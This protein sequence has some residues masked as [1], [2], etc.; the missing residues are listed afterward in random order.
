MDFMQEPRELTP[1]QQ[2]YQ[3]ALD[4]SKQRLD[5]SMKVA[6]PVNPDVRARAE[7]LST[8][9]GIPISVVEND[10][11]GIEL[12]DRQKKYQRAL[13][14]NASPAM[15]EW[16]SKPENAMVSHDDMNNM[17]TFEWLV[18]APVKAWQQGSATVELGRLGSKA[19]KQGLT[20][21]EE[22]RVT[23][24][25]KQSGESIGADG[26]AGKVY[27]GFFKSL[28]MIGASIGGGI[29]RGTEVGAGFATV[30]ALAGQAGPQIATPEELITVPSAYLMGLGVGGAYGAFEQSAIL[31]GGHA[32][33]E[34]RDIRGENGEK[35]DDGVA[36]IAARVV[37]AVNGSIELLGLGVLAKSIPGGKD[38]LN[39]FSKNEI[40]KQLAKPTV[41]AALGN[42]S[43]RFAGVWS[44]EV[45]QE[46][47]QEAVTIIG[48]EISK[49]L[50]EGEFRNVTAGEAGERLK[51]TA[52]QAAQE[53]AIISA[54]GPT[55]NFAVDVVRANRAKQIQN[56]FQSMSDSARASKLRERLPERFK[57]FVENATKDGGIEE[58]YIP[59]DKFVEYFQGKHIDPSE[60]AKA[61]PAIN[62]QLN[63]ALRSGSDLIIPIGDF[64]A[65]IAPSQHFEGLQEHL[66]LRPDEMTLNEALAFDGAK[67]AAIAD[68]SQ[69]DEKQKMEASDGQV[70]QA[71]YDKL[72][73]AG[74]SQDVAKMEAT[75]MAAFFTTMADRIGQDPME[76]FA[77]VGL[78]IK[79]PIPE[80]IKGKN[81]DEVDFLIDS[82]R[83]D[84]LPSQGK[85]LLE[86]VRERGIRDDR[87]DLAAMDID[88]TKTRDVN[89]RRKLAA[90]ILRPDG[91]T[92]D[93]VALAAQELGYF[94]DIPAGERVTVNQ[95]LDAMTGAEGIFANVPGKTQDQLQAA[96]DLIQ[97]LDERGIVLDETSN[98]DIKA[99]L[100]EA[101]LNPVL[102]EDGKT[103]FHP[104]WHGSPHKFSK[105]SL[106]HMGTGEGNQAY[107]WGL[108][109]AGKKEVAEWYRDAGIMVSPRLRM[110]LDNHPDYESARASLQSAIRE[111]VNGGA[112]VWQPVLDELNAIQ[113]GN[114]YQ[115]NLQPTEDQYLDWD[116]PL[117][118][119][120]D[121]VK[122]ML[123]SEQET[124]RNTE[125][126]EGAYINN[127]DGQ[128][129]YKEFEF[130]YGTP[131]EALL[132]LLELGIPGV[133]YLDMG[134]RN[135]GEGTNNYV[136][137][138]D[139]L[140]E[141]KEMYQTANEPDEFTVMSAD[142]PQRLANFKKWFGDSKVVDENGD[143]LVVY[144]GT[145]NVENID[146]FK[147]ELT[148]RG[149]DQLGSGFYFTNN[150]TTASG[151]SASR[152]M[153]D[154]EKLGGEGAAG[155]VP[156][157]L[158][159]QNP[160]ELTGTQ[161]NLDKAELNLSL[162]DVIKIMKQSP[163]IY[164][165]EMTPI[166]NWID[167]GK[168]PVEDW[169]IEDVAKNYTGDSLLSLENDMF[170]DEATAFRKALNNTLGYDGVIQKFDNGE[171]HYVAWFPEQIKSVFNRGTFD[172][173]DARI[174]YQEAQPQLSALHNLSSENLLFA[175]KLGGLAAPSIGI[176][177]GDMGIE[178]YGDIT[179]IGD[180]TLGDPKQTE[181]YDADA[182]TSTF[183]EAEYGKVKQKDAQ[184]LIDEVKP[185][186][187]KYNRQ[188]GYAYDAT[189]DYS[190]NTP[191][192]QKIIDQWLRDN[193]I[194]A[195]F[196]HD[197]TGKNQKV[198]KRP[199]Y[200]RDGEV[201]SNP[202]IVSFYKNISKDTL[203]KDNNSPEA[204]Q[205][206][207]DILVPFRKA[208]EDVYGNTSKS[209][210]I[211]KFLKD[212]TTNSGEM[213]F[214]LFQRMLEDQNK[215]G[216]TEVDDYAIKEALDKKLKGREIK[217]YE[218][219]NNKVMSIFG[220]PFIRVGG[221]KV[222][223]SLENIV[224]YMTSKG[225]QAKEKTMT[226]GPGMARAAASKQFT[227]LEWM[228]NEAETSLK[229]KSE[230][231]AEREAADKK[232]EEYR[233]A[234]LDYYTNKDYRGEIDTWNGLDDSM[235]ALAF[236]AKNKNRMGDKA[237]LKSGL[238]KNDFSS[239]PD[240]I[241]KLGIEAGEAMMYAP[242]PYFEAKPHRAVTL[243][244][245]AGAVVPNDVSKEVLDVLKKHNIKV[246]KYGSRY[247]EEARTKAVVNLRNT[248]QKSG[249]NVLFQATLKDKRGS[250]QL[251]DGKT[252]INLLQKANLSTFLHE[253]GHLYLEIFKNIAESDTATDQIKEDYQKI[254]DWMGVKSGAEIG[255]EQHEQWARGFEAY[256][257][258]GKAPSI[259]LQSA[260]RRFKAWLITIY[261]Q[262]RALN[263]ELTDEVRGVMDR[264]LAT[265]DQIEAAQQQ[266][267]YG[268]AFKDIESSGMT[269]AEYA[270][271]QK[272]VASAN[273]Q[274]KETVLKETLGELKRLLTKQWKEEYAK[275]REEI[276]K[277]VYDNPVFNAYHLLSRNKLYGGEELRNK[278]KLSRTDLVEQYGPEV[279]KYLPP[280]VPPIY[281][282][283]GGLHPD[284]VAGL[285]GMSGTEL[286]KGL[287]NMPNPKELIDQRT[288]A[289]MLE[290]HGDM[291]N[292]GGIQEA[293]IAAVHG[294]KQGEVIAKEL[295]ALNRRQGINNPSASSVAKAAAKRII[296]EKRTK[297]AVRYAY[298]AA[299]ETRA[300]VEA[301]KLIARKDYV[302]AAE[303]KRRQMLNH[304]LF[305][306]ARKAS[307]K[308]D[309]LLKYVSKF[310]RNSTRKNIDPDYLEKID[311]ILQRFDF[312]KSTTLKEIGRR[313]ALKKFIEAKTK[314]G[315]PIAIPQSVL[316]EAERRSYKEMPL[317]EVFAVRDAIKNLDHL[318]R[319][320]TEYL[321][322]KVKRE[323]QADADL[324]AMALE[325]NVKPPE[326]PFNA[327]TDSERRKRTLSGY[328]GL[329]TKMETLVEKMDGGVM[330]DAYNILKRDLDESV[331]RTTARL[332]KAAGDYMDIMEKHY[333]GK[334][335]NAV[336]N[337]NKDRVFIKSLGRAL[338]KSERLAVALNVGNDGNHIKLM[339]G[340]KWAQVTIDEILDTLNENDW[341]YVQDTWDFI[342]SFWPE[343]SELEKKRTGYAPEK[344]EA[345]PVETKYGTLRG[346]YYP[347]VYDRDLDIDARML[348]S[349][350]TF[351]DM[352]VGK[353]ARA[354]TRHGHTESRVQGVIR[355]IRIDLG[356]ISQHI[357]QVIVDLEMSEAITN[358]QTILHHRTVKNAI[359]VH[360]GADTFE[361]IDLWMKDVAIGGVQAGDAFSKIL[362]GLR[363]SV[364]VGAMGLKFSTSLIQVSG[365]THSF[366]E[367]GPKY[368]L[369]G[370]LKFLGNK[371]WRVTRDVYEK[372][373]FM[374]SRSTTFH[375][376][377]FDSLRQLEGRSNEIAKLYFWPIVKM[378]QLVDMP[379]WLGAYEKALDEG[380][381]DVDAVRFADLMVENSQG[382][383]L[384]TALSAIERGTISKNTRL[385]ES[386]KLWTSFYSYFNTKLNIA[387]RKANR[388]TFTNPMQVAQLAADYAMLFWMEALIGEILL[389]HMPD[390]GDDDD[391]ELALIEWNL[392][393]ILQQIAATLP[394]IRDVSSVTQ[395][396]SGA[397]GG[398]RGIENLGG[399]LVRVYNQ[400]ENLVAGEDFDAN[401]ALQAAIEAGN[402]LSPIKVPAGQ[403]NTTLE[404]IRK[405]MEGEDVAPMDYVRR[406]IK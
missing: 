327:Q 210:L 381:S 173:N 118:E 172:P 143:P 70:Y 221:R 131:K 324:I 161:A 87:G 385:S 370:I 134:S 338:T 178:G 123:N 86:F 124:Y 73:L 20:P 108:Y 30:T 282:K 129:I 165:M 101:T 33:L 346:G 39:Y 106:E 50:S 366:V 150:P 342:D 283:N 182:Y 193:G 314:E 398:A 367:V 258:E 254:L 96:E 368:M 354:Q 57:Q 247:D 392:K 225:V 233:S 234:V 63:D 11:D 79:G 341:G 217:F 289:T 371:P 32:Y 383:G 128:R 252:I 265:D 44:A 85:S 64:A 394:G 107:G 119:Q 67:E 391:P 242:V 104:A 241:V 48:G 229:Q 31:E 349:A 19:M 281:V 195:M 287:T 316:D 179:L 296:S 236:W 230:L 126:A 65:Y 62:A 194:K 199:V 277:Q 153:S 355:P 315:E 386:V 379:T 69:M 72:R 141:I 390:F 52:I 307:Q 185:W 207:K 170:S 75:Q 340:R 68:L 308:V 372:S 227:D 176:V 171:T 285:F 251:G 365:F 358:A 223:Y 395:G 213:N 83:N 231:K 97:F 74:R 80:T 350:Q 13:G 205:L 269:E 389:G 91:M 344:V 357:N 88:K 294:D 359:D 54:L 250:I 49:D 219:V 37:G 139:S 111:G 132:K 288:E 147:P 320:K 186:T 7:N 240:D 136:I 148:G 402:V 218:W 310:N 382:S 216:K 27:S 263:V 304:H 8:S 24:L 158:S 25:L 155:V 109:F 335:I 1:Q 60:I 249:E 333:P 328:M 156:V 399:A 82:L 103:F 348:D 117:S 369:K 303:A 42:L 9:T 256:M 239:V 312:R 319:K 271:Y 352:K 274:A 41:V 278:I 248:L 388:T 5:T 66:R 297:D 177:K 138:D 306:E 220:E 384:Q 356:V 373:P 325:K 45:A 268:A 98:E 22:K 90:D 206:R 162:N 209:V 144:H 311:D 364:S 204:R 192:P 405:D 232:L 374:Q 246:K 259:E 330:G 26:I 300:A 347:I 313:E 3:K 337:L 154:V 322:N 286:I 71:V 29:E 284:Q 6:T 295:A 401:K 43:K 267:N 363:S 309:S 135:E 305:I 299:A 326:K 279:L 28:P 127:V 61:V 280:A 257:F 276:E 377:V 290:R 160:I 167:I 137:F 53:F 318:G 211:E 188:R 275:T 273:A 21:L 321:R 201:A 343:I 76:F 95:F 4:L 298:Y 400:S 345:S 351:E 163:I 112:E 361:Q 396:F 55:S 84:T 200:I 99:A 18:K 105:F 93:D 362:A 397:P 16:M 360:M 164:D 51:E 40:R 403:I 331:I 89:D 94:P 110:V 261:K 81:I 332:Q 323:L 212:A 336:Q 121:Y 120:S 202:N 15:K 214:S 168:G 146:Q 133:R 175:D 157:Y 77:S 293:A 376:D 260:F 302:G 387:M 235:K 12:L 380:K 78:D 226:F 266:M 59:A 215:I 92:I 56:V 224:D 10:M 47:V 244:E 317:E 145:G 130:K 243:D 113:E 14:D 404:A 17:S 38:I 180:K 151:Y 208:L 140:I 262:I 203:N 334:F 270:S 114:V 375:R 34:F 197:V 253:S 238:S 245:F 196:L 184:S 35:I 301:Q 406:P 152:I 339:E 378:Q 102:G 187:Q 115:V 353:F 159:I 272:A 149:N 329:T 36:R 183:P 222:D 174:L 291:M 292:D 58:V 2:K 100:Q 393:L 190:V 169:M 181:I 255:V 46:V 116:K 264:M 189:W 125:G 142:D 23:D 228:R 237:A 166:W 191:N 198:I 122:K